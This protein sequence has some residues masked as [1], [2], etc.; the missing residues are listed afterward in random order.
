MRGGGGGQVSR[1]A[2]LIVHHS[3]R[4]R[5]KFIVYT[6]FFFIFYKRINYYIKSLKHIL[7]RY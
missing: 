4:S 2:K 5:K 6:Q 1:V 7:K 3:I